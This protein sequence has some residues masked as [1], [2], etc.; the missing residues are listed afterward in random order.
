MTSQIPSTAAVR[1]PVRPSAGYPNRVGPVPDRKI[2]DDPLSAGKS[3]RR[4]W[5]YLVAAAAVGIFVWL[6]SL[7]VRPSLRFDAAWGAVL[8]IVTVLCIVFGGVALYRRTRF[9]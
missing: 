5:E 6:A 4:W 1:K 7:A 9:S 2:S 3:G 8:T